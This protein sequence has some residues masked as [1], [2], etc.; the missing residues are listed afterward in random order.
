M[1]VSCEGGRDLRE[2][3]TLMGSLASS[4]IHEV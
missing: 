4:K 2:N 1:G 3:P